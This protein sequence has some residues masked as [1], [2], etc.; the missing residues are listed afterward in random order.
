MES[1]TRALTGEAEAGAAAGAAPGRSGWIGRPPA[2]P[3]IPWTWGLACLALGWGA[4]SLF[5]LRQM[6]GI[7]ILDMFGFWC[8]V[9]AGLAAARFFTLLQVADGRRR[10]L[11]ALGA[12]PGDRVRVA[13]PPAVAGGPPGRGAAEFLVSGPRRAWVIGTLDLSAA[14]R[15]RSAQRA[16]VRAAERLAAKTR[17]VA[18]SLAAEGLQWPAGVEGILVL[19]RRPVGGPILEYGVWQVNP[20]QVSKVLEERDRAAGAEPPERTGT[21][22]GTSPGSSAVFSD[23]GAAARGGAAGGPHAA[24]LARWYAQVE[25]TSRAGRRRRPR[26]PAR[27]ATPPRPAPGE[28]QPPGSGDA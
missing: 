28:N 14:T 25:G 26:R 27:R 16:L 15:R 18:A 1:S 6:L 21:S 2:P 19:T 3:G 7:N 24:G 11:E 9:G 4:G 23:A 8:L 22:P 5:R 12:L 13:L 20:E 17:A 10:L